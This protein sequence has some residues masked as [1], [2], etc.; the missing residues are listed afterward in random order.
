MTYN[1]LLDVL[2]IRTIILPK[3]NSTMHL[4]ELYLM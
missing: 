3:L 1:V 4:F 2:I